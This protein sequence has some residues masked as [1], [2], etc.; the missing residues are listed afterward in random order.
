L[1]TTK[2]TLFR[3]ELAEIDDLVSLL[4]GTGATFDR[5]LFRRLGNTPIAQASKAMR[6]EVA[7]NRAL[8]SQNYLKSLRDADADRIVDTIFQRQNPERVRQ[9][10]TNKITVGG[11]S[12]KFDPESHKLLQSQFRDAA[13]GRI[14]RSVGDVD[15]PLFQKDFLSGRLGG[16]LQTTLNNYG[17]ETLNATF[18]KNVTNDLFDLSEIMVRASDQPLA[19]K[20]GLAAPNIALGLSLFGIIANPL[21][22]LPTLAFFTGMSKALRTKPV[23][24]VLLASRKPGE[25]ALGQALQTMHTIAAQVQFQGLESREGP[26]ATSPEVKQNIQQQLSGIRSAIPNVAPAFG[27]TPA[28]NVDPTNPIVN[29]DPAT[30][31][32]AQALSQRPPS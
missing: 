17:R 7:K 23:L 16:K 19:G 5:A 28:A 4:G 31:A 26:L 9:F 25:D 14:L 30:Q 11:Q 22:T 20:G 27:G 2:N 32:L 3:G 8:N 10:M 6:E 13:M 12:V 18:G 15:S 1:G 24:N 21:A 29:P